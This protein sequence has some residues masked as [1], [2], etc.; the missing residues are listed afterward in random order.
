M[1]HLRIAEKILLH[2]YDYR[3]YEDRYEYPF[4]ITQQGIA[5]RVGISTAHVPRN[6]KKLIEDGLIYAKK[7]HVTGKKKR[8]TVYFLT[9]K[10]IIEVRKILKK[11]EPTQVDVDSKTYTIGQL[12]KKLSLP[13]LDIIAKMESGEIKKLLQEEKRVVFREVDVPLQIFVDR[14]NEIEKMMKWYSTGKVLSIVGSRGMGKTTLVERF[15]RL[16][17][18]QENILWFHIYERRTWSSVKEVF[19]NLFSEDDILDVLRSKLTLLIF[20]NYYDA[21]DTFVTALNS[22]VKEDLGSSKIIVCMRSDTPFY[23]RFYTLSDVA[24]GIVTEIKLEGLP[25]E[26]VRELLP[27]IKEKALKHIYRLTK[28]NPLLI[29]AIREEDLERIDFLNSDQKY[30]LRYLA[31]Q[32]KG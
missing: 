7:G 20:D 4:E 18:P 30:L 3:V 2:L 8:V 25:Y 21:D 13:I 26:S 12:K 11:M 32:K 9:S 24:E 16:A 29:I 6:I 22:L 15:I 27:H 28:G 19:K 5:K 17:K 14:E 23:N 31:S 10:G 1:M